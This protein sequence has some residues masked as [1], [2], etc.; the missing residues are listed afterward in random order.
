MNR[1][2]IDAILKGVGLVCLVWICLFAGLSMGQ[3]IAKMNF[4]KEAIDRGYAFHNPTNGVWQW[5]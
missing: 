5:K 2:L 3:D 1:E 4:Q